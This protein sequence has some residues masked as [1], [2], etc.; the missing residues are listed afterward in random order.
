MGF[1]DLTRQ[2]KGSQ[3]G[4]AETAHLAYCL[5]LEKLTS[6]PPEILAL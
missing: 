5:V 1:H 2:K 3:A 6:L 4:Y